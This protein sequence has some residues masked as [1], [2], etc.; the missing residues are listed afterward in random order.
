[1]KKVKTSVENSNIPTAL[2]GDDTDLL[3]VLL[4]LIPVAIP[5]RC[6]ILQKRNKAA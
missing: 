3:V 6:I 2:A 5:A 4:F 1:M